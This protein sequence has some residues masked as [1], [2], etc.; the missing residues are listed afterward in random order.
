MIDTAVCCT[1]A[2]A[3]AFFQVSPKTVQSWI[4]RYDIAPVSEWVTRGRRYRFVALVEADFR[5]RNSAGGRPR[6][7]LAKALAS[8]V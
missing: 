7:S 4:D 6:K 1:V 5:A 2:E 8:P 3:A